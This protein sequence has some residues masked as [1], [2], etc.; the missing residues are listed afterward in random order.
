[1]GTKRILVDATHHEQTRV[2]LVDG[3][4]IEDFE[5]EVTSK[6]PLKGNI[7]LARITRIEPSLQAAFVEYGGNRHGFLPFSEIHPDY[8][9]I[10]DEEREEIKAFYDDKRKRSSLDEL[11][12][13][14][15][16]DNDD[17]IED[18][19]LDNEDERDIKPQ[20]NNDTGSIAPHRRYNIQDVLK[21]RQILLVQ[22]VKE[23]RG[24]KG[25]ALTT[26]LSIAGRYCVLMPN[27]N[28]TGGVSRRIASVSDRRR[29]RNILSSMQLPSDMAVIVRTAGSRKSRLDIQRDYEYLLRVWS[30]IRNKALNSYVPSPLYEEADLMKRTIR[31]MYSRDINEILVAGSKGFDSAKE[32]MSMLI[33]TR[34]NKLRLYQDKRVPLF[35]RWGTENQLEQ[36]LSPEAP[37]PSGGSIVINPTEALIAIDVNSGKATKENSVEDTAVTTNLEAATEV[38]RQLRLR[39]LAGLVVIDFIDMEISRHKTMVERRLRSAL[40]IDRSRV[41]VGHISPFG[42]LEL[43]RQRTSP[44]LIEAVASPCNHCEGH[45]LRWSVEAAGLQVIRGIEAELMKSL[46]TM[47]IYA[48]EQ[49]ALWILNEKRAW[50][51]QVEKQHDIRLSIIS[52]TSLNAADFK[53]ERIRVAQE[54]EAFDT[55]PMEADSEHTHEERD[56]SEADNNKR[57]R[58]RRRRPNRRPNEDSNNPRVIPIEDK[59]SSNKDT[60]E[61]SKKEAQ[62]APSSKKEE[63]S[64]DSEVKAPAA[65]EAKPKR[66]RRTRQSAQ[67]KKANNIKEAAEPVAS[68]KKE[69]ASKDSEAKTKVEKPASGKPQEEKAPKKTR[70]RKTTTTKTTKAKKEEPPKEK[71]VEKQTKK[72]QEKKRGWWNK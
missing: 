10:P 21:R 11:E 30:A 69:E 46:S 70:T 34:T 1:M 33:P 42:L 41:Q 39:N 20:K 43:S 4:Q 16:A 47:L 6:K 12:T 54:P 23:E 15:T 62:S 45:G 35:E 65:Q 72:P 36:L 44:S 17:D 66:Q 18:I 22:V 8:F 53:I 27:T 25:A 58:R 5:V 19:D 51:N 14:P 71:V 37:L 60:T 28:H 48:S 13:T 40:N 49:A 68:P 50:I 7:Y 2:A 57:K 63:A 31:D 3:N 64:K 67:T 59:S 55:M 32:F 56:N 52:D 9:I 29:L 38:A 26:Y 24:N 61:A